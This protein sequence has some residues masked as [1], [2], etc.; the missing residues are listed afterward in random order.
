[1]IESL[2]EWNTWSAL[3]TLISLEIVLGID[4]VVFIAVL[5]DRLPAEQQK[6]AYRL[7]LMGAL[8]TRV[9]LLLSI[10]WIMGL[11][12]T[13]F[14]VL[15]NPLSG[16]DLILLAG[17]LFLMAK[18]THEIYDKVEGDDSENVSGWFGGLTGTVVQIMILDIVFSLDSVITAVGMAE[19]VWV[20]VVAIIVAICVM[21][22]FAKPIG[23]YVNKHPSM[24]V[25]ALSFLILI[26]V[27]LTAEAFDKHINKGYV[28]FAMAFSFLVQL[29]NIRL[30]KKNVRYDAGG[31]PVKD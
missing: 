7:G 17:G 21:L 23:D 22:F 31:N 1:M 27:L 29:V 26:G 8:V 16:R 6:L 9:G 11:G 28:Y 5:A 4:N 13:L 20:M 19:E 25:L 12:G 10:T 2:S 24:K 18:S 14:T 3:L 15:G 30:E